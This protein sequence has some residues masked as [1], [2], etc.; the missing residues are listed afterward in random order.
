MADPTRIWTAA[1]IVIG[2]EILSGRTQDKNISQIATWLNVQGIRLREVRVVADDSDAIVESV[3]IL[4]ARNDYL[5][6]TGGIG[7]THDDI[8]VDAIAAALGVPV[9]VHP[10]ARA[11]LA[12]YYET[13]GGLTEARLRMARV[14]AGASLIE[15]RMSGAPGIRHGNIFIMAGVPHITAGMLDSLTGTLEGG[16]PLLSATIG[17]W[18]AESEIAD[19][20]G[21]AE[22]AHEGCQIGSYPFFREGRTG[23][24]FVVRSTDASALNQ[25]L[26]ALSTALEQGGWP[27]IP[28]G[29]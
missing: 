13:R 22:Q 9:E 1:L 2:D 6:T 10:Q 23:A 8:T 27:V 5:F 20:L 26:T 14:P 17:C 29:I 3:N 28:N 15:N 11:M 4:R 7:P 12:G 21:A 16:L 24:N 19:L 18:V 25:C